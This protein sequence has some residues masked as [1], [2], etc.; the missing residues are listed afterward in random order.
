MKKAKNLNMEHIQFM[1]DV[2]RDII[3]MKFK[4]N[5]NIKDMYKQFYK[6]MKKYGIKQGIKNEYGDINVNNYVW[7]MC[8]KLF[9][10]QCTDHCDLFNVLNFAPKE[11][12]SYEK[13]E[14]K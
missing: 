11:I 8:E 10:F 4:A 5:D 1:N 12:R 9:H 2:A 3:L 13:G 6:I 7:S 14:L